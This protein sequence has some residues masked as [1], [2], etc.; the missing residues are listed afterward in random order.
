MFFV[1][2]VIFCATASTHFVVQS[3]FVTHV[4]LYKQGY[5]TLQNGFR[6]FHS[7]GS[8]YVPRQQQ[9]HNLHCFM[10]VGFYLSF[11]QN[12]VMQRDNEIQIKIYYIPRTKNMQIQAHFLFHMPKFLRLV[13]SVGKF[14]IK[15]KRYS[16]V[17]M[18]Y[19]STKVPDSIN[20]LYC[21]YEFISMYVYYK[22]RFP[23]CE[24]P[25]TKILL[26]SQ[27]MTY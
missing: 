5:I 16:G 23:N 1:L 24:K 4:K 27:D 19:I 15:S 17:Q 18:Y 6:N 2:H 22:C 20:C 10:V 14:W 9:T 25:D 12:D 7:K 3:I 26:G 11:I 13:T 8:S 21:G